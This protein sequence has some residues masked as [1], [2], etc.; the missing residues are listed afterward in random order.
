MEGVLATEQ[1]TAEVGEV[2]GAVE[3]QGSWA[4]LQHCGGPPGLRRGRAVRRL[5]PPCR[6]MAL[7]RAVAVA[8]SLASATTELMMWQRMSDAGWP[9]E[10]GVG[11]SGARQV[12]GG[13]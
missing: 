1:V 10:R 3:A 12:P 7:L 8:L 13:G 5:P 9:R 2:A 11:I 6:V 4:N